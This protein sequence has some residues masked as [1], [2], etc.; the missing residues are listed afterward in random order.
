V[1]LPSI[2]ENDYMALDSAAHSRAVSIQ[3]TNV[4]NYIQRAKLQFAITR[5]QDKMT[6]NFG[7]PGEMRQALKMQKYRQFRILDEKL[8][9][10]GGRSTSGTA[11]ASYY[12]MGGLTWFLRNGTLLKDFG[13]SMS[14]SGLDNWF[15]TYFDQNPDADNVALFAAPNV[16]RIINYF[17][18]DKLV[19][20]EVSPMKYGMQVNQYVFGSRRVDLIE[21]PLLTDPFCKGWGWILDLT[22][23]RMKDIQ[24]P[25]YIPDALSEGQ[26][27]VIWDTYA[28]TVSMIMANEWRHAMCINAL[29]W[30]GSF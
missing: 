30:G 19:V 5:T 17:A 9:Y 8:R 22:R 3:N 14:E 25:V 20:N 12:S 15:G 29:S 4:Y 2:A 16:I 6:T 27:D 10:F 23:I 26:S 28:Q 1:T 24:P 11:P 13:G 21:L 7:G 18:K